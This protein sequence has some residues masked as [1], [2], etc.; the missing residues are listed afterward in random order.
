[1][2]IVSL[3]PSWTETLLKA[4]INVVGRT[5]FC[6]YP[7]QQITTIPVVG[8]T[9]DIAWDLVQ[10]L[11]PDLVLMDR[12]ENPLEMAEEC[13]IPYLATH[14]TSLETLQKE[15]ARLGEVF[16][17]PFL[18]EKS[19]QCLDI[20]EAPC[21]IWNPALVPGQIEWVRS[22]KSLNTEGVLNRVQ[23]IIWK[24]PWMGV[25]PQTY[26]GSVLKKLG[27]D[28]VQVDDEKYPVLEDL[29]ESPEQNCLYLFSSEPFPFHKKI[30]DLKALNVPAVVVDGEAYSWFG[31]RSLDFLSQQLGLKSAGLY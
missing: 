22:A 7:A 9:K 28:V 25:G 20:V 1:M 8:G 14:V 17:N 21:K 27:A 24:K 16:E 6:L 4:Q 15:L 29:E 3:V 18:M 31:V 26:I 10:D 30:A 12:E 23:Y 5:R 19:A 2:R 11:K 13:P